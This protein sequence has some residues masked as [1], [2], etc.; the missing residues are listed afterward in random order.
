V[1]TE[2]PHLK[3]VVDRGLGSLG[4]WR[5]RSPTKTHFVLIGF[6]DGWYEIQAR[7]HDGLTGLESPLRQTRVRA[8]DVVSKAAAELVQRDF[9]VVG[10]FTAGADLKAEVKLE[11]KG[12]DLNV[13]LGRWVKEKEVFALAPQQ[14]DGSPGPRVP[15]A[16]LRVVKGPT[17]GG[18]CTC[19]LFHRYDNIAPNTVYRCLKL[20][21]TRGALRIRVAEAGPNNTTRPLSANTNLRVEV[22]TDG[23]GDGKPVAQGTALGAKDGLFDT[24]NLGEAGQFD[25]VA[26]VKI[27]TEPR[28]AK[29]P[30]EIVDDQYVEIKV[31]P[32]GGDPDLLL[33]LEREEWGRAIAESYLIQVNLFQELKDLAA[34]PE[35]RKAAIA[36]AQSGLNRFR[37]DLAE[38]EK[39][40]LALKGKRLRNNQPL[41]L[42]RDLKKLEKVKE[43]KEEL[44]RFLA[45]LEDIEKDVNDPRRKRWELQVEQGLLAEKDG[46]YD[47][48]IAL[49]EGLLK[50]PYDPGMTGMPRPKLRDH[51]E[52]IKADW[53]PK[54]REHERARAYIL[55][56]WPGLSTTELEQGLEKIKSNV[57]VCIKAGDAVTL[58]KFAQGLAKHGQRLDEE[59]KKLKPD[60]APQDEAQAKTIEKVSAALTKLGED[61][62]VFL[63]KEGRK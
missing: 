2:H 39:Q 33:K 3:E 24:V 48:A 19:E 54:S 21:T 51:L 23:F 57:D 1:T 38:L 63:D 7:Q 30:V 41:D 17:E 22:R 8:R 29:V 31:A 40:A 25:H 42:E 62:N 36:R 10:T 4:G 47:R 27:K 28:D 12:G 61:V 43:G 37:T 53:A 55:K 5:E 16:L 26:F 32:S 34:Q 6:S 11:L 13:A 49:Y 52:K 56:T 58:S 45:R 60:L 35:Q 50:D 18:V 15:W 9:G 59:Y 44:D 14:G 20:G 46:D